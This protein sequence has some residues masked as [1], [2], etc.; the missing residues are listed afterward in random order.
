MAAASRAMPAALRTLAVFAAVALALGGPFLLWGDRFTAGMAEGGAGGWLESYG[1]YAWAAGIGL[2]IADLALPVPT[3]AIMAAL[4]LVYGPLIGGLVAAA[5]SI[6]SGL[7]GYGVGR[8]L[9]RPVVRRLLGGK[10]VAEG[11]RLFANVGGWMVALSRWLPVVSE[12]VACMAGL[13]RMRFAIFLA[14]L[15]CGSV[16]LAF[17]FAAIGEAGS[18]SPLLTLGLSALVPFVLWALLRPAFRR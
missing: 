5:G 3:T 16:P 2:L 8:H 12:V 17:L 15:V 1:R 11:D 14:A 13:A 10:A 4:G 7:I 9:G 6:A 18:G